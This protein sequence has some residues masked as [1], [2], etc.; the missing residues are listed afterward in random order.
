MEVGIVHQGGRGFR[1][2]L[3]SELVQSNHV[4]PFAPAKPPYLMARNCLK[5]LDT[6]L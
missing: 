3:G 4:F 1:V 2:F 5:S 6:A